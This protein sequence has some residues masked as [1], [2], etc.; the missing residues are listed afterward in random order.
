MKSLQELI[1]ESLLAEKNITLDADV[2]FDGGAKEQK[3]T[4]RKFGIKF[5]FRRGIQC[6]IIGPI[7]KVKKYILSPDGYNLDK[8]DA[9]DMFP[10]LF[11][12]TE[13][14]N[15]TEALKFKD[16]P[17]DDYKALYTEFAKRL[18][19]IA[20]DTVS[21]AKNGNTDTFLDNLITKLEN[22]KKAAEVILEYNSGH[23]GDDEKAFNKVKSFIE[24]V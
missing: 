17:A 4:E 7:D 16:E 23:I 22:A 11:E 19:K 21:D 2:D 14:D 10:E 1:G 15:L 20:K 12:S 6:D 8:E 3:E 13:H 5:K 9:E 24:K 18:T